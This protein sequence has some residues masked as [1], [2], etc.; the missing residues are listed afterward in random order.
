MGNKYLKKVQ[1]LKERREEHDSDK[2]YHGS[3][4]DLRNI[5]QQSTKKQKKDLENIKKKMKGKRFW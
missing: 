3:T 2:K 4:I 1:D 5:N